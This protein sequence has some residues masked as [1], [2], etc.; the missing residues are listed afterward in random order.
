[1]LEDLVF[2]EGLSSK[3]A[4]SDISGRGVGLAA[5]KAEVDRLGGFVTVES[6]RGAGTE[7]RF[8]LPIAADA[9]ANNLTILEMAS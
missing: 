3:D 8:R 1:L 6:K 2:W 4:A 5:V 9:S 7:F